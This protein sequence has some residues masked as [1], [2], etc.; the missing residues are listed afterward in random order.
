MFILKQKALLIFSKRENYETMDF[1]ITGITGF[2]APHLTNFLIEKGHKVYGLVR[3]SNGR[4]ADILDIVPP[5]YFRQ[6]E[7]LYG[8]L[9]DY[10]S[11][12]KIFSTHQ[13]DGC[14]HLAAQSHPPTSFEFPLLTFHANII[15][16]AN[17]IDVIE[18]YQPDCKLCFASTS[19]VYGNAG[20]DGNLLTEETPLQPCNPYAVSKASIDLYMQE[21]MRNGKIKGFVTR[22]FS[23]TGTRRGKNF[24]ISSDAYQIARIM[25]GLQEPILEVG[26]LETIRVVI[27]VHDVCRAYYLLMEEEKSNGGIF[28]VC[29]NDS[30]EHKMG[31]FTD[32]LIKKSGK[33]IEKKVSE[34]YY[35]K[36]DIFCQR[37][38][39]GKINK[40]TGWGA[41]IP[42]EETLDNLL[43]YWGKKL[44][45][46]LFRTP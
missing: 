8:D 24:S 7:F 11:L 23:H 42:I 27:D 10:N 32:Y 21:R 20:K 26:N 14:F 6:I 36:I 1:L 9:T 46:V 2:C 18:K 43:N 40:I 19:E 33:K 38:N 37:G 4:E 25:K 12:E 34:K 39:S 45:H 13:F 30:Y 44:S 35:R 5:N 28:N 16:S 29:G 17:L 22:A 31:F 3:G 15:G 41:Q